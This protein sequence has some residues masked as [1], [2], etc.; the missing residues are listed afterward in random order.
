MAH[1]IGKH[2]EDNK[3]DKKRKHRKHRNNK[4]NDDGES[5]ITKPNT[6]LKSKLNIPRHTHTY[7]YTICDITTC[8]CLI[9]DAK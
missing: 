1:R 8:K 3:E 7:I 5:N 4:R 9:S 6:P 2:T